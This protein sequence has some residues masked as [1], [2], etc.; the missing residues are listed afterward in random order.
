MSGPSIGLGARLAL[1][2]LLL[3]GCAPSVT[4][5]TFD[6]PDPTR[7][8]YATENAVEAGD[9]EAVPH[10]IEGLD[11]DDPAVRFMSVHGLRRLTGQSFGYD[12]YAPAWEREAAT[13]RWVEAWR[14]GDLR[15]AAGATETGAGADAGGGRAFEGNR[16]DD[17]EVGPGEP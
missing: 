13:A 2:P 8:L 15:A 4:E 17:T 9:L 12:H 5:A 6:D 3:V 14:S 16:D 1:L 7:R 10:L 11:S